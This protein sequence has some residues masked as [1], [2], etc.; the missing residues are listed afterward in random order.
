MNKLSIIIAILCI[1][2]FGYTQTI[3]DPYY[4]R[5]LG[6]T[7]GVT[8]RIRTADL[9]ATMV[10]ILHLTRDTDRR[11]YAIGLNYESYK[12]NY[13]SREKKHGEIELIRHFDGIEYFAKA[14]W[15]TK[16][17]RDI[18]F[19]IHEVHHSTRLLGHLLCTVHLED[20]Y[21]TNWR[22]SVQH[23]QDRS[24]NRPLEM[25]RFSYKNIKIQWRMAIHWE[26]E[27]RN[28]NVNL[29]RGLIDNRLRIP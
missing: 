14:Y 16:K 1:L 7:E 2:S 8:V 9:E 15:D 18:Y 17:I 13:K 11:I 25:I 19:D 20:A 3:T 29:Y 12:E 4:V 6:M 22:L 5:D 24:D 26:V 28:V 23:G 21:I 27:D 10:D